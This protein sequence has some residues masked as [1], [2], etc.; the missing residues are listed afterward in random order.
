M[1]ELELR[2]PKE[3]KDFDLSKMLVPR[4]SGHNDFVLEATRGDDQKE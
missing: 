1:S 4:I 3:N 2:P